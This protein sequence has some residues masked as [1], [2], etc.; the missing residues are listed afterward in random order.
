MT[1]ILW[2][3]DIK[4]EDIAYVGG[5]GSNLG[6]MYNIPLPIPP[7]FVVT[8]QAYKKFVDYTGIKEQMMHILDNTNVDDNDELQSASNKIKEII[9]NA[10]MPSEIADDITESYDNLN[11]NNDIIKS[12]NKDA[13][14]MIKAGRDLPYVAVRSSATAEDLPE[15][16]FAGQQ[17]TYLN[18]KGVDRVISAVQNCWASLFTA[19]AIYYRIK[20]NFPHEKVLIAVVIQKMVDSTSSGVMF[21]ANPATNNTNEIMI[22]AAF[23]LGEVVV[24]GQ[25]TPDTYIIDKETLKLKSKK[26]ATQPYAL[27]RGYKDGNRK[28]ILQ[29]EQGSKQKITDEIILQLAEFGKKIEGHYNA[30]QDIEWAT[31]KNKIYI[32][33]SRAITTLLKK[34]EESEKISDHMKPIL[35]GLSASPGIATGRVKIVKD[36]S[37][38]SKVLTGDILVAVMTNPDYVPSM[39]RAAAIVTDEGGIT[40]FSGDTKILTT[41]GFMQFKEV[42]SLLENNQKIKVLSFNPKTYKTEWKAAT[43]PIKRKSNL[44]KIGVSQRGYTKEN[45]LKITP[46]HKMVSFENRNIIKEDIS[47]IIAQNKGVIVANKIPQNNNPHTINEPK[48]SYLCGA[49]F[50]DGYIKVDNRRGRVTFTQKET[51]EKEEFIST[52]KQYY[53]DIFNTGFNY[54]HTKYGEGN[55]RGRKIIGSATDF[56][57]HRKEPALKLKNVKD[58]LC[59]FVLHLDNESLISFLAGAIDGDG[60]YNSKTNFQRLHIYCGKKYLFE[61]LVLALLRLGINYQISKNRENCYNIQILD[62]LDL[63]F[64][65]TKRVKAVPNK[66]YDGTR[67][68]FAKQI[69]NDIIEDANYKGRIK[70]YINNNLLLDSDKLKNYVMPLIKNKNILKQLNNIIDSDIKM[71]RVFKEDD[72][73]VNEVYNFEVEDN[74]T[75]IVFTDNFTPIIVWNC[76]AAIVSREMGIP[77]IVGTEKATKVL[78]ENQLITVDATSGKVYDGSVAIKETKEVETEELGKEIKTKTKVYMNLGEPEKIS[79]YKNLQ[80]DGIGLM[81]IEFIISSY[82]GKHPL[83]LIENHKQDMYIDKLAEGISKVASEINPK[84]V[85]V[86]F[87]DFK[88]N[89]YKGLEGGDRFEPHE[90]NPL[91]GWRGVSRYISEDFVEAFRLECKAIKK[92]RSTLKNVHVMLPFVRTTDEVKKCLEIMRTEDL[93]REEGFKVWLMAEVPSVSIIPEEFAKLDIDGVSIGSNDLTMLVLGI[94]RDSAKLGRMGYFDERNKAVLKAIENIIAGFHKFNKTV[95]ICGQSVSVYPEILKFVL[96]HGINSVSVN[97]D[98]VNKV[99]R[100]VAEIEEILMPEE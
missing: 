73:G 36:P 42:N 49:L 57:S 7:G 21:T 80:F 18:V 43:N 84:P 52:V 40:C 94:D 16:S 23:G 30:P 53:F 83:F 90:D 8:A 48:L 74:H 4:K 47:K 99:K 20:N 32:V 69:L 15:A 63:I 87:S 39:K 28:E 38:L 66:R 58:N 75:Y 3:R 19:R 11:V 79:D 50:T 10:K 98:V 17:E 9:L 24:G 65:K 81:R 86:R 70:P 35:D 71:L 95:S 89:E 88:S 6:E 2:F 100:Q 67:F 96:R 41:K 44:I 56:I 46:D 61:G 85:I 51:L 1:N 77:S 27:L 91:I 78:K 82:I 22:E 55:I 37:E 92:V 13:L 59:D 34:R 93:V 12:L 25:V 29:K 54:K 60:S 33:Q 14:D 31:E 26:I 72:L 62:N 97:P 45:F 76:H 64:S 5:K 68:F